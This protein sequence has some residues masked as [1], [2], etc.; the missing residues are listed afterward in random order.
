MGLFDVILLI[1]IGGFAMFGLWFGLIHTLGSFVGTIFGAFLASRFYA[2]LA[3]WLLGITGWNPN[4]TRVIMFVIAF[5]IINRL[6]GLA[7]WFFEKIAQVVT[8]LPFLRSLDRILGTIFGAFEGV[9]TIG[10]IVYFIE[11]FPVPGRFMEWMA[12]SVVA[13][14]T[15]DVASFLIPL[16]PEGLKILQSTVDYIQGSVI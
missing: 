10:L 2:P 9:A 11:R 7:F 12:M 13:P 3:D 14:W 6:V 16:L 5:L 1:I 4:T 15:R 8:S